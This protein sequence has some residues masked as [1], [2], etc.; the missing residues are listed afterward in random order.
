MSAFST[1]A[2][3]A[4]TIAPQNIQLNSS[5]ASLPRATNYTKFFTGTS[6]YLQYGG[7]GAQSNEVPDGDY[8]SNDGMLFIQLSDL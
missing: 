6:F 5:A 4:V 3:Q 8:S 7:T 2:Q 1:F